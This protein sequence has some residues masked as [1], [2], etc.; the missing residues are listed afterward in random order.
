MK[1]IYVLRHAKSSWDDPSLA[2][3]D[4]PLADRGR[5]A[6]KLL[7]EHLRRAGI[8]PE[9]VLSSSARRTQETLDGIAPAL[10]DDPTAL[11]EPQLY[12]AS[13]GDLLLRLRAIPD[14]VDSV[15]VIGHNP[16]IQA[17]AECLA[18]DGEAL[19]QVRRKYP[20]GALATLEFPGSWREL[21]PGAAKL[22]EFVTPKGLG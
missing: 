13:A 15:M 11:I 20:T 12:L 17:F 2:D 6:T 18:G 5:R 16:G 3:H 22:V 19:D 1:R 4:R 7:A 10:G 9:L 14:A 8:V 21:E